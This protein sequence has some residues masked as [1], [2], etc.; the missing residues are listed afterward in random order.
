MIKYCC[1][2]AGCAHVAHGESAVRRGQ[3][4][5]AEKGLIFTRA[6]YPSIAS[7]T[8]RGVSLLTVSVM[9]QHDVVQH[10]YRDTKMLYMITHLLYMI[11]TSKQV[12]EVISK[13]LVSRRRRWGLLACLQGAHG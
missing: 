4:G 10:R 7:M 13:L 12:T 6:V 3:S 2:L 9:R 1:A 5:C 11:T 8:K